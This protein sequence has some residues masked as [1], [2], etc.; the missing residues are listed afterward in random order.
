M[1]LFLESRSM[2]DGIIENEKQ[3][4]EQYYIPMLEE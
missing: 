1:K 4:Q 3:K 2:I